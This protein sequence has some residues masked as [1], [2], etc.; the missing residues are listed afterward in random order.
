MQIA[1]RLAGLFSMLLFVGCAGPDVIV[2]DQSGKPIEGAQVTGTSLSIGGGF[3]ITNAKGEAQIPRS[4]HQTKWLA[5][6]KPGYVSVEW[7]DP[8]QP[9]PIVVKLALIKN[10][11]LN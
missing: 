11:N 2:T 3:T 10:G 9:R 1:I 8:S 7:I 6:T 4:V 5:I